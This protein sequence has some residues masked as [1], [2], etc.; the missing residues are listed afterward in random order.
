MSLTFA[1]MAVLLWG[2][3]MLASYL[4]ARAAA[5]VDPIVVLRAE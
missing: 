1:G 4:P 2:V 5:T 3:A